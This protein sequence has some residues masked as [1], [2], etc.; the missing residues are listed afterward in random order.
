M[1]GGAWAVAGTE[2]KARGA[3]LD[4][5]GAD[6]A[7]PRRI[8]IWLLSQ[9]F[10]PAGHD[11]LLQNFLS[12][13]LNFFKFIYLFS[14]AGCSLLGQGISLQWLLLLR[15]TGSRRLASV[16]AALGLS[17]S[18]AHGFSCSAASEILLHQESP[19]GVP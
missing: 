10:C 9:L 5:G 19:F 16:F 12:F 2:L 1:R 8:R 13:F 6:W 14:A 15:N 7:G 4:G 18:V 3:G 17:S 11:P